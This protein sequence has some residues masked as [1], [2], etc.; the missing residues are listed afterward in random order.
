[1]ASSTEH[2]TR[3]VD[4]IK[5]G[6]PDPY[7]NAVRHTRMAIEAGANDVMDKVAT[8]LLNATR[9]LKTLEGKQAMVRAAQIVRGMKYHDEEKGPAAA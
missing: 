1:M 7:A 8:Y 6:A 5:E 2:A 4:K 9:D 3:A